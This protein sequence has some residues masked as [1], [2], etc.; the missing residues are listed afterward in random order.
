LA[1]VCKRPSTCEKFFYRF[2]VSTDSPLAR[3]RC[4]L[5]IC[6]LAIHVFFGRSPPPTTNRG[7]TPP[8][9]SVGFLAG[10]LTVRGVA[11]IL[12]TAQ[13]H[14][15]AGF[16]LTVNQTAN[17]PRPQRRDETSASG[18]DE[19]EKHRQAKAIAT[20]VTLWAKRGRLAHFRLR[21]AGWQRCQL[22]FAR[23]GMRLPWH[24][25]ASQLV[26]LAACG[27]SGPYCTGCM[28]GDYDPDVCPEG[29][30]QSS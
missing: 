10:E 5:R 14:F 21:R 18:E 16:G 19:Q 7:A 30:A 24:S 22:G 28:D 27:G 4:S 20:Q 17:C 25:D 23:A 29:C 13:T 26:I 8:W 9:S 15:Y 2:S 1:A 3:A 12:T 11:L 6:L